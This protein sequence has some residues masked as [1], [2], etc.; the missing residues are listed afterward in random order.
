[1]QLFRLIDAV[2]AEREQAAKLLP[3]LPPE[4]WRERLPDLLWLS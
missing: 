3:S 2:A 1:M 4:R